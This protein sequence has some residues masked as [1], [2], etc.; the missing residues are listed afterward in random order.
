MKRFKNMDEETL[1]KQYPRVDIDAL[2]KDPE[3]TRGHWE[4]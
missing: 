4:P 1:R 2:K 3:N